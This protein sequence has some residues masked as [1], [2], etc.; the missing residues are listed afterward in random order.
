MKRAHND[1]M[2]NRGQD[3]KCW[4]ARPSWDPVTVYAAIVGTEEAQMW[5][6][7]GTDMIDENGHENWNKS[8][9][10]NN[11][12]SL[13][14]TNNDKKPGVVKIIDEMLCEGN[15]VSGVPDQQAEQETE[16]LF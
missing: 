9:K 16:F 14:F 6:E 11:E 8:W 3:S 4:P 15:N 1:W 13:W 10:G 2:K 5:E 12:Y 7:E